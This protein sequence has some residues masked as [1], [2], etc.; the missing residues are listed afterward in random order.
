MYTKYIRA[1]LVFCAVVSLQT[2]FAQSW[3]LAGTRAMGMDGAG[4]ATAYGPDAPTDLNAAILRNWR[5]DKYELKPQVRAGAAV[6][7][8][9]WMTLSADIDVTENDTMLTN[10]KSRQ[11][12]LGL[13]EY[14]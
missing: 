8:L 7:P 6:N 3:Q 10:V 12:A 4:V 13:N 2:G 11:L 5:S 9:K 14:C 1:A